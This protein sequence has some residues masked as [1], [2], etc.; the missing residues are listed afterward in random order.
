MRFARRLVSFEPVK[1]VE[2]LDAIDGTDYL[3]YA[4]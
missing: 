4:E 2:V 3:L 1:A